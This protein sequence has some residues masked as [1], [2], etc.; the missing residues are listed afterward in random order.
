MLPPQYLRR[1]AVQPRSLV[2]LTHLDGRVRCGAGVTKR[3][4][5]SD[6]LA[7][8]A[9]ELFHALAAAAAKGGLDQ[10]QRMLPQYEL[11]IHK[12]GN[13]GVKEDLWDELW[14]P[15]A[16]LSSRFWSLS[17]ANLG[18]KGPKMSTVLRC[19]F[20]SCRKHQN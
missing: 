10:A 6:A 4:E 7:L 15:R 14:D 1:L 3:D 2:L 12:D 8:R 9:H 11:P 19:P 18:P 13:R 5:T 16:M 17:W 20:C